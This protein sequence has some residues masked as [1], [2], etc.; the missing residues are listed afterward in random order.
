MMWWLGYDCNLALIEM[1]RVLEPRTMFAQDDLEVQ[2][3]TQPVCISGMCVLDKD[4]IL[5]AD[6]WNGSVKLLVPSTQQVFLIFEETDNDW[7][8][9]NVLQLL[10]SEGPI[11]V[12]SEW[13][14]AR[15][16]VD[17]VGFAFKHSAAYYRSNY[18]VELD[19]RAPVRP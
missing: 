17:R 14:H 10:D 4:M 8:V 18:Y 16:G 3:D 13:C 15:G 9:S 6:Y 7:G 1:Q 19:E 5:L 2:E 11:L 12:I